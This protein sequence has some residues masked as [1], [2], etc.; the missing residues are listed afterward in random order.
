[1]NIRH[2][3][4]KEVE[5]LPTIN[6]AMVFSPEREALDDW[7]KRAEEKLKKLIALP[8]EECDRLFEQEFTEDFPDFTEYRF[9]FQSEEG[10]FV[11]CHLWVNKNAQKNATLLENLL[12]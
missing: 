2:S 11:P 3:V 5:F 10:E 6:P 1:M 9:T 4:Y 7:Q 8:R 12:D